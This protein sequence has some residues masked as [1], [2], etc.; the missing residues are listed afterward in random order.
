M[1]TIGRSGIR[2]VGK[3]NGL[4]K[5][6]ARSKNDERHQRDFVEAIKSSAPPS[7]DIEIGHLSSTL[8]HLGNIVARTNQAVRFDPKGEKIISPDAAKPFVTRT[9]RNGHWAVPDRA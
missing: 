5:R 3:D 9:Y 8:C 2:V 4:L 1:L 6:I 7:A